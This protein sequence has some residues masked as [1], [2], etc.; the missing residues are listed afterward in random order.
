MMPERYYQQYLD[1][2]RGLNPGSDLRLQPIPEPAT[3]G[4]LALG[5][6]AL[7]RRRRRAA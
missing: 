7:A 5:G 2:V 3:I 4:L 1:F 6:L